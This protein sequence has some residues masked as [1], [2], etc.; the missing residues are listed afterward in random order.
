VTADGDAPGQAGGVSRPGPRDSAL[1]THAEDLRRG[2]AGTGDLHAHDARHGSND[3]T[4]LT[5]TIAEEQGVLRRLATLVAR[6]AEPEAVFASV[7]EE[8][9]AL[10]D[11]DFASMVQLK[12]DGETVL[13]AG[14]G[15]TYRH[16]R[17]RFALGPHFAAAQEVWR[18]GR[19]FRLDADD[20]AS[21]ELPEEVRAEGADS[22]VN[23]G[24][25]VDGRIWGLMGVASRHGPL[26]PSTE[27]RL[28]SF[29]ELIAIAVASA[30]TSSEL[31]AFG[32]EQAALRRV[33]TLV[34]RGATSEDVFMAVAEE[35]GRLLKARRSASLPGPL[36]PLGDCS[37]S[38]S[39]G[40][41]KAGTYRRWCL[42][43]V[44]RR[45]SMTTMLRRGRLLTTSGTWG[46]ERQ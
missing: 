44:S 35:A 36:T 39:A 17:P 40:S 13:I 45:G 22:S 30:Q 33:A 34:A 25:L 7:A 11:A 20:L 26:P 41:A 4:G 32:E 21:M 5:A 24:I 16:L 37:P 9:A 38:A 18:T 28:V 29:T 3:S 42:N 14:Y 46:C 1:T 23:A 27:E 19:A 43:L 15:F 2:T 12:P 10:F 31:R 8:A 6:G